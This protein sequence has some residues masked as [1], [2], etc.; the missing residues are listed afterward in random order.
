MNKIL[1]VIF[2]ISVYIFILLTIFEYSSLN[3]NYFKMKFEEN[4][5][6]EITQKDSEE[7]IEISMEIIDYLKGNRDNLIIEDKDGLVFEGRELKH[8]EDVRALFDKGYKIKNILLFTAL[9]L[10]VI[11]KNIYKNKI[12]K[13]LFKGGIIFSG[14]LIVVGLIIIFNFNKAF[15]IF[16]EIL[17]S[18]DLWIL[19]PEED[20]LI[21]MLPSNF[22]SD[23]GL[24]IVKRYIITTVVITAVYLINEKR[25]NK[26]NEEVKL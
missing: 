9:V 22:F 16:H 12:L 5:T 3:I 14:I 18:N 21:Q 19:N 6:S 25:I 10:A 11:L 1:K 2:I 23:L 7:L 15:I 17:F 8:M 20:L 13:L 24:L 4:N 26:K